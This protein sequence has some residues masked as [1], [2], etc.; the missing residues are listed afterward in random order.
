MMAG[1]SNKATIRIA[2]WRVRCWRD[3]QLVSKV[4]TMNNLIVDGG[5]LAMALESHNSELEYVFDRE[6][7]EVIPMADESSGFMMDEAER[8]LIEENFGTRF[9][10]I[11]PVPSNEGWDLMS[12]FI[13]QLP[14]GVAAERLARA[15]EGRSP[16]RRFKDTLFDY[17]D[18]REDW[19]KFHEEAF[20]GFGEAWLKEMGIDATLKRRL[21]MEKPAGVL[22]TLPIRRGHFALESGM[23]TDTWLSLDSL[24][25]EPAKIAPQV[26]ALAALLQPY[27]PSAICGP[28]LGGAFLAQ[29]IAAH[30]ELSFYYTEKAPGPVEGLFGAEY[31]LPSGF[32][33][34]IATER[35]AIV[36]DAISA[37]SSARATLKAVRSAGAAVVA[38]GTLLLLGEQAVEHF[39]AENLPLVAVARR[40]FNLWT[41]AECPLCRAG[42]PL[43]NPMDP[44]FGLPTATRRFARQLLRSSTDRMTD[45]RS[46]TARSR[47]TGGGRLA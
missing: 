34:H 6:S 19:F 11:E 46:T 7:G 2:D 26:A 36:D 12:D 16:F 1:G 29:A 27:T 10:R 15:I 37:G 25:V 35:I 21:Q 20:Y 22:D 24:F 32:N 43:V 30:M 47:D 13:E 41:P 9:I 23:H 31:G 40:P 5:E 42:E 39:H 33:R 4:K 28:L 14:A 38:V 45:R 8:E 17:P 3:Q 18:L 44:K